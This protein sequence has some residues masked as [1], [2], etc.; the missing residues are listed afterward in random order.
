MKI[1]DI[2]INT[3]DYNEEKDIYYRKENNILRKYIKGICIRCG[4]EFLKRSDSK[5]QYCS[6]S[7]AQKDIPKTKTIGE[8]HWNWKGGISKI[9][10]IDCGKEIKR[11][12]TGRCRKCSDKYLVNEL[13]TNWKGGISKAICV[14]CGKTIKGNTKRCKTCFDKFNRGKN[15]AMFNRR[16]LLTNRW[17]AGIK[18]NFCEVCGK[19]L[20]RYSNSIVCIRCYNG[21]YTPGYIDGRSYNTCG[22]YKYGKEFRGKLKNSI[23]ERDGYECQYP[24]CN[25][26]DLKKV[27]CIHHIDYNKKNNDPSN[28]ISLCRNCHS[29]TNFKR[30]DWIKYFQTKLYV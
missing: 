28:L 29:Q 27:L 23:K 2:D 6:S 8:T 30:S 24:E 20:S 22:L 26:K 15:N 25:N 7:C 12:K 10:C 17:K 1:K 13:A 11:N 3:F 5:S 18:D 19:K 4:D 9:K 16:G 21:K 14:D